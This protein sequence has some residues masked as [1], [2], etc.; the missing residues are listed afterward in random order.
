MPKRTSDKKSKKSRPKF[1]EPI[2]PLLSEELIAQLQGA[3]NT[4]RRKRM[5]DPID[6]SERRSAEK[7]L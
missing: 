6:E 4:A 1:A 3:V 2:P 5:R 7:D